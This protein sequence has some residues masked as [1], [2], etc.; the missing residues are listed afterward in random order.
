MGVS[1]P[2]ENDTAKGVFLEDVILRRIKIAV[3]VTGHNRTVL[4]TKGSGKKHHKPSNQMLAVLVTFGSSKL[5]VASS[6]KWKEDSVLGRS[7][8][9][10]GMSS[11]IRLRVNG[12]QEILKD[13]VKDHI[14]KRSLKLENKI[15]PCL[16][17]FR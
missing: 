17:G 12:E 1:F 4:I 6:T 5:G 8:N 13:P 16:G 3:E 10:D 15:S 11:S 14:P 9:M 2:L 7:S